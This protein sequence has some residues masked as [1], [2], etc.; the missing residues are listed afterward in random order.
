MERQG[1]GKRG[2]PR[3]SR[4]AGSTIHTSVRGAS[5]QSAALTSMS[6]K[7]VIMPTRNASAGG[8][9]GRVGHKA[10]WGMTIWVPEGPLV[11]GVW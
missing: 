2:V 9:G 1:L 7:D 11:S 4:G 8:G 3:R 6:W 5:V 10:A